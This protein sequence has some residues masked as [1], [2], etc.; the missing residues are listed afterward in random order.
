M[1]KCKDCGVDVEVPRDGRC[2]ACIEKAYGLPAR[3]KRVAL[4]SFCPSCFGSSDDSSWGE[5]VTDRYCYNCG[6]S[7]VITIPRWAVKS[8]RQQASW[9]GKRYYPNEED[10]ERHKELEVLRALAP[11]NPER[12]VSKTYEPRSFKTQQPN[13]RGGTT[14]TWVKADSMDEARIKAKV[15]LPFRMNQWVKGLPTEPGD[16]WL[17]SY[18]H[19]K[20]KGPDFLRMSARM[21]G[22]NRLVY[23]AEGHFIYKN[24]G[25]EQWF[26]PV[27]YPEPP[28]DDLTT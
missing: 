6:N 27:I 16:Y 25:E 26:T 17:Y 9:V 13:D 18:R 11:D 5:S 7:T 22:N 12:T 4:I 8:I 23:T 2:D 19:G 24:E 3:Q 20:E 28:K 15:V 1:K 14:S 10:I 21:G